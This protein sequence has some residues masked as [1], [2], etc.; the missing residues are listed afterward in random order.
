MDYECDVG[1]EKAAT[2]GKCQQIPD[3]EKKMTL[4]IKE[5]Q[6]AQCETYGYYQITQGYRRIPG[7]RCYGG[8]DLNPETYSCSLVGGFFTLRTFLYLAIIGLAC[9]YGWPVIEALIIVLPIPDPKEIWAK[10]KSCLTGSVQSLSQ[11]SRSASIAKKGPYA[12]DFNQAPD[13]LGE[14][15]EEDDIGKVPK[16]Q[17]HRKE[18]GKKSSGLSYGDSD[19]DENEEKDQTQLITLD[20]AT[21]NP[22]GLRDRT[23]SAAENIPKL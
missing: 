23:Q 15:D 21:P 14:S 2:T 20:G 7:N 12:R 13:T 4:A 16:L 19:D 8:L 11:T 22:V 18:A 10:V 1:Y 3:Y 9:Y 6:S 5:D 17:A